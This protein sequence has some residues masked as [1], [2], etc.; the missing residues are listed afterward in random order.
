MT[1]LAQLQQ[2][3][4]MP[5]MAGVEAGRG[6]LPVVRIASPTAAGEMYLHGGHVTG[7]AP[8]GGRQVLFV[9]DHARYEDGH[10]IRG[11]VPVCF[12]WFGALADRPDAPAH[13][14]VRT[15]AWQL[16]AID[17]DGDAVR[18]TMSTTSDDHTRHD[19]PGDF[20]L[21]HAVTFGTSLA[22]TLTTVNTG[23]TPFTFA[24]A[25]HTYYRVGDIH[26]VGITGLA[27]I[28]YLDSLDG[29]RQGVDRGDLTFAGEV[30]RIYLGSADPIRIEDRALNRTL[31]IRAQDSRTTVV[32]NPW[33][34]KARALADL[35]DDEWR[36]F[37]CVETCNVSPMAISLA[38]GE[39]HVMRVEI[40][41]GTT[42]T[43]GGR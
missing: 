1:S 18:V 15:K 35:G 7:W 22:M 38:P 12:P 28:P 23:T 2:Q 36:D 16:D 26:E 9:S 37:V 42:G 11:G 31:A 4:N 10:A 20:R 6:G 39:R 3:F 5:G 27:G 21:E 13:G 34:R 14:C 19:W 30:D 43:T 33:I 17:R 40:V 29:R 24:E 32:W 41:S 25:L 8:A